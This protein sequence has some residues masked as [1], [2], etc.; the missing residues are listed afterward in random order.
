MVDLFVFLG[1]VNIS[2]YREFLLVY[3]KAAFLPDK[4]NQEVISKA[5]NRG[6]RGAI[7]NTKQRKVVERAAAW[8]GKLVPSLVM[9]LQ[10]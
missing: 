6:M 4:K 3:L 9:K 5:G 2:C 1:F 10:S 7:L 8:R